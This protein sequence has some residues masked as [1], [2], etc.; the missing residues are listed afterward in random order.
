MSD[1]DKK[2]AIVGGVLLI[3]AALIAFKTMAPQQVHPISIINATGQNPKAIWMKEHNNGKTP[4][5]ET[6]SAQEGPKQDPNSIGDK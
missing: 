6:P 4:D 1:R 2:L 5:T 3:L